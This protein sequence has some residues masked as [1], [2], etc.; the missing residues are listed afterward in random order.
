MYMQIEDEFGDVIGKARRGQE[1]TIA[2]LSSQVGL[3]EEEIKRVEGYDLT[4]DSPAVGRLARALALHPEKLQISADKRYF[5]LYPSGRPVEGLI[6]E[7]MVLGTDF[8]MNGYIVGC[9]ETGKGVVIDPGFDA[10]R[11][12]R[13][14]ESTELDIEQVL[15]T[16]GHA[17]HTGALSE[18]CQ[19]VGC[20]ARINQA[21]MS[22]LGGLSTKIEGGIE[23]GDLVQVGRQKFR[24]TATPG[25]TPGGISFVHE[26][27][28]VV[29][30]ALFAGSVGGTRSQ[31]NYQAQTHAVGK[32]LLALEERVVLYPGHGPATTVGEER[33]NN[34]FF[35]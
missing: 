35:L 10:E 30:D 5:P 8:L 25:H 19:A 28:A 34:P 21:D 12:L 9:E 22:L 2:K 23:D 33:A 7:M 11:I 18:I 1:I 15:L 16:H 20:P 27:V 29:G 24:T 31:A 3:T 6:V 32:C 17:D 14:V 26:H 13:S 4:P